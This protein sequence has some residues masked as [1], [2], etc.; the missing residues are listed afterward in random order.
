MTNSSSAAAEFDRQ[1]A[2]ARFG[3]FLSHGDWRHPHSNMTGS[4]VTGRLCSSSSVSYS[5]V[6]AA[7]QQ[8]G[9]ARVYAVQQYLIRVQVAEGNK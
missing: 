8:A 5:S 1:T 6:H 7:A 4:G 2:A 9:R 3:R